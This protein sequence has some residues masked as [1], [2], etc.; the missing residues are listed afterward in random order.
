MSNLAVQRPLPFDGI[1]A[2]DHTAWLGLMSPGTAA[3]YSADL[4]QFQ[5][6]LADR[7]GDLSAVSPGVVTVW[8]NE[9]AAAGSSKATQAR[10]LAA[11]KSFYRFGRAEGATTIDPAPFNAPRP[12]RDDA[13]VGSIDARQAH[14]VWNAT[15]GRPRLRVLVAA[16]LFCG[17]RVSEAVALQVGDVQEQQGA[18][19][20]RVAGKGDKPRTAVLPAVA[21]VAVTEWLA[22]RGE[23]PGPL[24]STS[25][26]AAMD[27]RA[28]HREI[29]ALGSRVG[30]AGLH[31]HTLRHTFATAAANS[32]DVDVMKLAT[33]M[34]HA[35][36][37]TT[38]RYIRGRDV[39][40]GSPVHA[41]AAAILAAPAG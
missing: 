34:G 10:K 17:L 35:S 33:A 21:V 7:G 2:I 5:R 40:T 26:G 18:R 16:L 6:W 4:G 41:V 1:A 27:R 15:V 29:R 24:L 3:G 30:V 32:G 28:A 11:V 36:P 25:S 38:M 23:Q 22:V 9:L 8:L 14:A 12:Q 39:I 19:V 31:P 20:L 13:N 37:G